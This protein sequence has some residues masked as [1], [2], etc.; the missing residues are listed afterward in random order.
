MKELEEELAVKW[1]T[2]TNSS[3]LG[4]LDKGAEQGHAFEFAFWLQVQQ[5]AR[6]LE[7]HYQAAMH[8]DEHQAPISP[9]C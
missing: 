7:E 6:Q 1:D 3:L 8:K 4:I 5:S 9:G 2:V